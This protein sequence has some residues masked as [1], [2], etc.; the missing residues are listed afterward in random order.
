[1]VYKVIDDNGGQQ[2][3]QQLVRRFVLAVHQH[4]LPADDREYSHKRL[5]RSRVV[6]PVQHA[7]PRES[8]ICVSRPIQSKAIKQLLLGDTSR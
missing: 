1:M 5:V 7:G 2:Y 4:Y 6:T 3:E 8:L